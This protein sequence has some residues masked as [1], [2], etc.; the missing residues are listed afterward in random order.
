MAYPGT[1]EQMNFDKSSGSPTS[2][3]AYM[4]ADEFRGGSEGLCLLVKI[5][6]DESHSTVEVQQ[7][8]I[9]C[10]VWEDRVY[11]SVNDDRLQEIFSK[12]AHESE[13]EHRVLRLALKGMVSFKGRAGIP[14]LKNMVEGRHF[15]AELDLSNLMTQ[16]DQE[17]I[18]QILG[19]GMLRQVYRE[20]KVNQEEAS[21]QARALLSEC[22]FTLY[23]LAREVEK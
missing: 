11:E 8:K 12:L 16:P 23:Q 20:L 1:H 15:H 3:S 14:P 17:E 18:Q 6:R 10:L 22:I 5:A 7:E 19:D 13:T 4:E 9:G 2:G 21:E